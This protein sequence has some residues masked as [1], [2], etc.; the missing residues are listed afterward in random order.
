M[1]CLPVRRSRSSE[2][3][4]CLFSIEQKSEVS[5]L[6]SK[7]RQHY[8]CADCADNSR[9]V[10]ESCD[11]RE[12]SIHAAKGGHSRQLRPRHRLGPETDS[13][14][15]SAKCGKLPIVQIFGK[16]RSRQQSGRWQSKALPSE[17]ALHSS[18]AMGIRLSSPGIRGSATEY[19]G[20]E[21]LHALSHPASTK[22]DLAPAS[23][24]ATR[25]TSR[26]AFDRRDWDEGFPAEAT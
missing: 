8:R 5:F 13:P 10:R 26:G 14:V 6:W 19:P 16:D 22:V 7:M 3:D 4:Q 9:E 11:W 20:L 18:C 25:R 12:I 23:S 17:P 24:E 2:P 1:A 15:S 21:I